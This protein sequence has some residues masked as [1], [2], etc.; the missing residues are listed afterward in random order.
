[1]QRDDRGIAM[2]KTILGLIAVIFCGV[3]LMPLLV[4]TT[5]LSAP[6]AKPVAQQIAIAEFARSP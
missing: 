3:L 1:M 4:D 2:S 5:K 6:A